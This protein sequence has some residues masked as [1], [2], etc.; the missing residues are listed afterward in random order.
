MHILDDEEGRPRLS[1]PFGDAADELEQ[2]QPAD[3]GGARVRGSNLAEL[4][5][6]T[7]DLSARRTQDPSSR[8]GIELS[9]QRSEDLDPRQKGQA[10]GVD[11]DA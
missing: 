3:H 5:D 8:T 2:A 9:R 11:A 1:K 10:L 4:G 6:K 7:C